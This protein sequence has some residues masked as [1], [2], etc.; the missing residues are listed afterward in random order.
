VLLFSDKRNLWIRVYRNYPLAS[1]VA[2]SDSGG[3][4]AATFGGPSTQPRLPCRRRRRP[5]AR[6]T[7]AA[8]CP[9]PV[10]SILSPGDSVP[11][12]LSL[13]HAARFLI[14]PWH[15]V[16]RSGRRCPMLLVS[17][18]FQI[19]QLTGDSGSDLD[20]FYDLEYD[21]GKHTTLVHGGICIHLRGHACT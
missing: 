15:G 1:R 7:A 9:S 14:C 11:I 12:W 2:S 4:A 3:A 16:S 8:G 20:D 5:V 13:S 19:W 6:R 18:S 21:Q 10:F 17:R